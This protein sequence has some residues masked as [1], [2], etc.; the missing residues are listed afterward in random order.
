MN[1]K[2]H[3]DTK[4]V[5]TQT[6]P[7]RE[8]LVTPKQGIE[9]MNGILARMKDQQCFSCRAT[10]CTG[11]TLLFDFGEPVSPSSDSK[12]GDSCEYGTFALLVEGAAWRIL[13]GRRSMMT[14]D[15]KMT[16]ENASELQ[17]FTD[18][19]VTSG[20][21]CQSTLDLH[22]AFDGDIRLD[23]FCNCFD[24]RLDN[25]TLIHLDRYYTVRYADRQQI[26]ALESGT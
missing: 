8:T 26:V 11:S 5:T 20:L 14:S 17:I 18:R 10:E 24:E 12:Y 25:Y 9:A 23:V 2:R 1:T 3:D 21:I 7:V 6:S 15:A 19:K 13:D 22:I 16:E 4:P